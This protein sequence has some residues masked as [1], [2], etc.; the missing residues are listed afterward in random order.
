MS[1]IDVATTKATVSEHMAPIGTRQSVIPFAFETRYP[2][3]ILKHNGEARL[4][5]KGAIE[6]IVAMYQSV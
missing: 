1:S 5:V 2:G 3:A 6:E 4:I